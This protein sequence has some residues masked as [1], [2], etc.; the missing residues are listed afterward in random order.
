M[1]GHRQVHTRYR[2]PATDLEIVH[3][4]P[5]NANQQVIKPETGETKNAE[6]NN[7]NTNRTAR[8]NRMQPEY[9]ATVAERITG[10]KPGKAGVYLC[11]E[12][13]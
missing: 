13:R 4:T 12:R 6:K 5:G 8:C 7:P 3:W 11:K 2:A 9:Q 1:A 10:W